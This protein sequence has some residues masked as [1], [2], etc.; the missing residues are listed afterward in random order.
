M[1]V[2]WLLFPLV[3]LAV[4][5]GC[6]LAVERIAGWRLPGALLAS[7]GLALIIVV[8]TLT[9]SRPI[10]APL[11][12]VVVVV[13][14]LGGYA[15]GWRRMRGLRPE[16]WTL[17]VGLGVFAVC[18]APVVASGSATFLGYFVD[19]DPAFH[20]ALINQLL[21]HGRDLSNVPSLPYSSISILLHG[22]ISTDY[23][24]GADVGLGAVRPLVGQ[25]V[26]W[27]YQPYL[28]VIMALGA[29]AIQELL[30]GVVRSRPLRAACAFIA[31]QSGL[32]YAFY[33]DGSIKEIATTWIITVTVVLVMATLSR[34][35]LRLRALAPLAIAVVAGLDVLA[36]AIAPWLGPPLAV[37]AVVV[38]WRGRRLVRRKPS[39]R[40]AAA[41]G[42]VLLLLAAIAA[43][44][45]SR[46]STFISTAG[47]VLT[48][49][50]DLGN[51][52][53]PL[54]KWQIL[55][56]WPTGDFRW[57]VEAHYRAA[58]AL[59]GV[60]LASA[61]LGAL[62]T[63]R[64]RAFG[65]LMLI[66]GNAIAAAVLL[67]RSSPYAASKVM[68]IVSI[69]AVLA[70]M[71][72]AVALHDS[73]R[74]VEGWGLAAVIAAGVLWT[75]AL[76][77]HDSSVAPQARFRELAAIGARFNGKGPAFYNLYDTFAVYFLRREAVA[78]PG[79]WGAAAERAGLPP[80][81][82]GQAE[83][84]WDPN[85]LA[86]SYLQSFRLLVLGRSPS[87]SRPP[88][89]YRL[90]NQGHYYD[91][92]QRTTTTQVLQHISLS[93]GLDPRPMP[94]CTS[95]T[96][97]GALAAREHARL[98]YVARPTAPTL[99][100][101][102]APHPQSWVQTTANGDGDPDLLQLS[103]RAGA[104]AGLVRVARPGRYQVWLEG[105]LSRRVSVWVGR[106]LVGSV[107]HQ[108]GSPGQF[109][110]V[111][112]VNLAAGDQPVQIL[113]PASDLRPG[114]VVPG[115]AGTGE[116]LGPLMLVRDSKPPAVREIAPQHARSLCGQPLEWIEI[117][118]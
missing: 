43:P 80:R 75:N 81:T 108:L 51:L 7:V 71:L 22:Y 37:F 103:Q 26:A 91:V 110:K 111:G 33:L 30:R 59:M 93:S 34:P 25:D 8:A 10:T 11:T 88:A 20:F 113:R 66:V 39:R 90:V 14:A 41:A 40:V 35:P 69:T 68:M 23:P 105:S 116:L 72:G 12:T 44:I 55:G 92:W 67:S 97:T 95:I 28:A 85:D 115:Y 79:T 24:T 19:G 83:L 21:A 112:T 3:L 18:A 15:V 109:L 52:A 2:A 86:Q 114:N 27:I 36:I 29:V 117:V 58:Y 100:P 54:P 77:Y 60:A 84:A 6:G 47:S 106:Q 94:R 76:G 42:A 45:I 9:T 5:L 64:R 48:Q 13:V 50:G 38:A 96:K 87:L 78:V 118:R 89:D 53:T 63:L 32:A 1:V 70:A 74:R 107:V 57:P 104:V 16:P 62:W 101:T 73:G 98:A 65:P 49:G 4:C 46:A 56:I 31:G 102:Q 61:T 17:V 99:I 82:S